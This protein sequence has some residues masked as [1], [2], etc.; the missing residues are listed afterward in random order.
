MANEQGEGVSVSVLEMGGKEANT[1][2]IYIER[3]REREKQ[4]EQ[5]LYL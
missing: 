1:I 4:A 3:E 5:N 2:Y